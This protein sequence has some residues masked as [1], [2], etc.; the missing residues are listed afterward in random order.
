MADDASRPPALEHRV[1][2]SPPM[3]QRW[4]LEAHQRCARRFGERAK[5]QESQ[6]KCRCRRF[7]ERQN[8]AKRGDRGYD[9]AKKV[10]DSGLGLGRTVGAGEALGELN[11]ANT[12]PGSLQS[13]LQFADVLGAEVAQDWSFDVGPHPLNGVEVRRVGWKIF[14]GETRLL[15]NE[16]PQGLRFVDAVVVHEDDQ[17]AF[18]VTEEMSAERQHLWAS[19]GAWVGL[20]QELTRGRDGT[21][22]RELV[23]SCFRPKDRCL[24]SRGPGSGHGGLQTEAAFIEEDEGRALL[25]LFFPTQ[26]AC[27]RPKSGWPVHPAPK[28]AV[29]VFED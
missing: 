8:D 24:S 4:C 2:L 15:L 28:P 16:G 18:D 25:D 14:D 23:P 20:L 27:A 22:G 1:Y 21:E 9:G 26:G 7:P 29:Q 6:T 19:N 10:I 5:G 12:L 11:V 17:L 13:P 3:V